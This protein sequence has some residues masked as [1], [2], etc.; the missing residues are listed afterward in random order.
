MTLESDWKF[1]KKPDLW[2]GKWDEEFGRFSPE[3]TKV[4]DLGL[5]LGPFIQSTKCMSLKFTT[6]LC[7][8]NDEWCKIWK[9]IDLSVQNWHEEYNKFWPEHS[10]ISKI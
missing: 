4:S 1:V 8:N 10:K 7:Y 2:F 6:D 3:R 9:G 5:L